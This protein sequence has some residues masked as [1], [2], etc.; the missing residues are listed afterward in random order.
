MVTFSAAAWLT[1]LL[2]GT[3]AVL[4]VLHGI[5]VTIRGQ[6]KLHERRLKVARLRR[7]FAAEQAGQQP[8]AEL[9]EVEILD[10]PP[11]ARAHAA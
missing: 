11:A 9:G 5:A 1:L 3:G 6:M 4:G 7:K 8:E 10:E 2:I